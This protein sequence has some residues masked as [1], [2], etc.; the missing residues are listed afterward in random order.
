MSCMSQLDTLLSCYLSLMFTNLLHGRAKTNRYMNDEE[1]T[2][3]AVAQSD[4]E[5]GTDKL[6]LLKSHADENRRT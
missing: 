3:A 6:Y 5:S 1:R 2:A 4:R